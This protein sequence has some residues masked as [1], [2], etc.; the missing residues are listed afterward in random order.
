MA[1]LNFYNTARALIIHEGK[2]LVFKL[3]PTDNFW[4]IPGGKMEPGETV[5]QVMRR[6]L[7]EETGIEPTLGRIVAGQDLLLKDKHLVEFFFEI[8]NPV[9]YLHID[10][11]KTSHGH[12]VTTAEFVDME[13]TK[14]LVLPKFLK[15]LMNEIKTKGIAN[16][17]Y[18]LH[19]NVN[20]N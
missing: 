3:K 9:D 1:G 14:Y 15:E 6:E 18:R 2:L 11:S 8:L 5:A 12:E 19:E 16:I 7:I 13:T 17:P 20:L 10:F 4:S